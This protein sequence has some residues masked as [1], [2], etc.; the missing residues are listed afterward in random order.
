MF[1]PSQILYEG[2]S[3]QLTEGANS[4][5]VTACRHGT[6]HVRTWFYKTSKQSMRLQL[7][8]KTS[9]KKSLA[10][11]HPKQV[12]HSISALKMLHDL[13]NSWSSFAWHLFV[14]FTSVSSHPLFRRQATCP[15]G[16]R[17]W[18]E[19]S[20]TTIYIEFCRYLI[21]MW[22]LI[23]ILPKKCLSKVGRSTPC[24][25]FHWPSFSR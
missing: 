10:P 25:F 1:I 14:G 6:R 11:K 7:T 12:F 15:R 3:Y 18:L 9:L 22:Y 20:H 2:F 5:Y 13:W 8:I 16:P 21:Y 19:H 17:S 24:R 4:S 23:L